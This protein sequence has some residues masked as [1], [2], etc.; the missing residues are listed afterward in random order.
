MTTPDKPFVKKP[1]SGT[2]ESRQAAHAS[3]NAFSRVIAVMVLMVV[4][5]IVGYFLDKWIGT[6]FLVVIGF[7]MGMILAVYGLLIVAKQANDAIRKKP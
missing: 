6:R 4:P 2:D 1:V 5:G 3:I 7:V